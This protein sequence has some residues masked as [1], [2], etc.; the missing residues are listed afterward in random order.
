MECVKTCPADLSQHAKE[1]QTL[2]AE[3]SRNENKRAPVTFACDEQVWLKVS[4]HTF[5]EFYT[6]PEVHLKAQLEG[7]LWF[8]NNIIGDMQP[9]PPEQWHVGVQLWMEENEFFGCEVVYQENDYAWGKPV[10][11]GREDLLHYLSDIDPEDSVRQSSSFRMYQALKEL[12]QGTTFAGRPVEVTRP[13]GSTHGIFTKAAEIRGLERMCLDLYDAPDF[14]EKFLH[15][16]T[17]KTIER[18]KAWHKLTTGTDLQLPLDGGFHFCDDSLQMLSAEAY[19]QFVLPCHE[20]LY[21]IMTRGRRGLHLCGR[22]S[23]HF[24]ALYHKLNVTMIDGPGPFVDHG[25][26]LQE[27]GP[28]FAFQ[29]QTDHSILARGSQD[30]IDCMIRQLLK[31]ESKLPG[32]FQ[33]MGFLT[34]ETPLENMQVCYQAGRRHGV[35]KLAHTK[36]GIV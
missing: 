28:D 27:F 10:P 35:I 14:A 11:I 16:V 7:K 12:S 20:Y 9:G 36:G 8:C 23:Q 34:R 3:Y 29:A 6:L 2:W 1:V 19:E 24:H 18:I 30:E 13:G 26:Y 33:I 32:R 4:G 5:R 17:E 21:S 22:A 15:L 25:R 31:P